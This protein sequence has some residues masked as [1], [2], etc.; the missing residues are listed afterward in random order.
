VFA[1]SASDSGLYQFK[2]RNVNH[3]I[4]EYD[5]SLNIETSDTLVIP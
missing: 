3:P 1:W 5:A 4:R 2:V